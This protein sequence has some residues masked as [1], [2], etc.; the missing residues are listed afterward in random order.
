MARVSIEET[1]PHRDPPVCHS[2]AEPRSQEGCVGRGLAS[3]AQS[4][5]RDQW[6]MAML[7]V[8]RFNDVTSV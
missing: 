3:R 4:L 5:D 8:G 2:G 7:L 6:A 1:G